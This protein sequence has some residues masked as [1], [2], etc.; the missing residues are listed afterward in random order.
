[1][2]VRVPTNLPEGRGACPACG[3]EARLVRAEARDEIH[4]HERIDLER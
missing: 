3:S 1:M 4:F 2:V